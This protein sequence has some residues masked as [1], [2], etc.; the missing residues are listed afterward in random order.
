MA[1][2]HPAL[3]LLSRAS[4]LN[5]AARAALGQAWK[6]PFWTRRRFS[7]PQ[8]IA[9]ALALGTGDVVV[10]PGGA[11]AGRPVIIVVSP[12]LPF[13]LA[14][15]GA[16]RMFNLMSR[17]ARDFDQ[18]LV[19]FVDEL[20]PVPDPLLAIC[21]EV[22]TIKR[23]GTHLA[24]SKDR[25][26]VVEDFDRPAFHA[27]LRETVRKWRPAAVQLEF[28]QMAQYAA[29]CAPA[30]TI[31]VEHDIT[32]DLYQQLLAQ[33]EDWEVRRQLRRWTTFETAAWK[34]VDRVVTMSRKDQAMAPG[35]VC[36]PNGVDL[37]R[38]RPSSSPPD[39]LRVLFIG[40]FAHLPNLLAMDFFLRECW[41][42]LHPLGATMHVIAG[43][44]HEYFLER[45]RARV[46]PDLRQPGV[47]LE[48]F[49]ADVRPAYERAAVVVAP[50]LASAGTNIK[51]MEAMAMGKAIVSTPAGINGL[52]LTAGHDVVVVATGAEMAAAVRD[53]LENP[54]KRHSLEKHARQTVEQRFDWDEI[55]REQ[56][57]LYEELM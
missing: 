18:V 41:P 43:S 50:L 22:V 7:D 53:L 49:V 52:H 54:D 5:P 10:T 57:R 3:E 8:A 31:L 11:P 33:G 56:K 34:Q 9:H 25:P 6:A 23:V 42:V 48:G 26:D 16:V 1:R 55:A 17:A 32:L 30:K 29:D 19:A 35:S 51:I 38:F 12:Y 28:T 14:H 4:R 37:R 15:G 2:R 39:S 46:R 44:R 27:A 36:L 24:A 20:A 47:E 13:P 40:S 21:C 45:Y